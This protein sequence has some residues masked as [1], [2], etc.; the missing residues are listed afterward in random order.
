MGALHRGTWPR[1]GGGKSSHRQ[2]FWSWRASISS[3][4]REDKQQHLQCEIGLPIAAPNARA[5]MHHAGHCPVKELR[6]LFT[7]AADAMMDLR[8]SHGNRRDAD[9]MVV[10]ATANRR[11]AFKKDVAATASRTYI[12]LHLHLHLAVCM[13]IAHQ[14]HHHH[15]QI[16][17]ASLGISRPILPCLIL[18]YTKPLSCAT[19]SVHSSS[20]LP[21]HTTL[22]RQIIHQTSSYTVLDTPYIHIHLSTLRTNQG[23]YYQSHVRATATT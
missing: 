11:E 21:W 14:S 6:L 9:G 10:M 22:P 2:L 17:C 8:R 20:P 19:P 23:P 15:H 5:C 4:E 13:Y 16:S 7:A 3:R 18:A 1:I 12:Y